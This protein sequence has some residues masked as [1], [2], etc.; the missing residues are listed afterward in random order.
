[1]V[2]IWLSMVALLA[3]STASLSG[4]G[5]KN[6]ATYSVSGT[7]TYRGKPVEG[8]GV[9]FMPNSGRPAS[10]MTDAQGRF[11]LRTFKDGDGA[12]AGENVVCISKMSPASGSNAKDPLLKEMVSALPAR[13]ATPTTSP[14]KVTVSDSALN[15]FTFELSDSSASGK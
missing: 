14:L 11:T 8:A 1:M 4:C 6:P 15:D 13:Y 2:R 10:A 7:V 3:A 5:S 9:M 12:I